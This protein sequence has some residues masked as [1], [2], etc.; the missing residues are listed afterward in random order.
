M[1]DSK[2]RVLL[3][4]YGQ[5]V[6]HHLYVVK[7][8]PH[9]LPVLR[10]DAKCVSPVL[11]PYKNFCLGML[12]S[13]GD[14]IFPSKSLL[15]CF[16]ACMGSFFSFLG[17]FILTRRPLSM[18]AL[19]CGC[20]VATMN[21]L[22]SALH[23]ILNPRLQSLLIIAQL[24]VYYLARCIRFGVRHGVD[25]FRSRNLLKAI[26]LLNNRLLGGVLGVPAMSRTQPWMLYT[27]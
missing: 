11:L 5:L 6:L 7:K 1:K 26:L 15:A 17:Q 10:D 14:G 19:V 3:L 2:E 20:L 25:S 22:N 16:F 27:E 23:S 9:T 24:V 13:E 4:T 12:F 8:L 18:C 21:P